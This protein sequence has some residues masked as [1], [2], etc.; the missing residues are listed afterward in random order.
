MVNWYLLQPD[1]Q[2]DLEITRNRNGS[3][4]VVGRLRLYAVERNG[5]RGTLLAN[6][7]L[8]GLSSFHLVR[9]GS[10]GGSESGSLSGE[11]SEPSVGE[12]VQ[13]ALEAYGSSSSSVEIV[14]G[15]ESEETNESN[16][17]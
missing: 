4:S 7:N 13:R 12:R 3:F 10:D 5:D 1:K 16:Q 9:D 8:N 15:E 6:I 2:L 14:E 17:A 11:A